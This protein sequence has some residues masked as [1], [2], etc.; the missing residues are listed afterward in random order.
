MAS[1]ASALI[2]FEQQAA[3]ENNNNWGPKATSA[4]NRLEEAIAGVTAITLSANTTLTD[5]QY[6]AN[7]ARSMVLNITG[8]GG[9]NVVIPNRTKMYFVRNG[10]SGAAAIKTS[11]GSAYSVASGDSEIVWCDGSDVVRGLK[12]P[13]AALTGVY[14]EMTAAQFWANTADKTVTTDRAWAAAE[15]V[16]LT[17][18]ATITVDMGTFINA[19]VTLGGNRALGNPTNAKV[20]QSGFIRIVQDGTGSRTL[21]YGSDWKFSNGSD[22]TLTTTAAATDI[23]YYTVIASSFIHAS[24]V[25]AVA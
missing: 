5:T 16:A 3:G 8:A 17:D 23:L 6:D 25:K 19:T 18:A 20:G 7:E 9:F 10:S 4:M 2:K 13:I 12:L 21:S 15:T 1:T 11:G 24:L 22:P 14:A